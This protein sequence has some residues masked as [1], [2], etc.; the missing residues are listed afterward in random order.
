MLNL[1]LQ[2][3]EITSGGKDQLKVII[4]AI[5]EQETA[6]SKPKHQIDLVMHFNPDLV[7]DFLSFRRQ[8][9]P[10]IDSAVSWQ[11]GF[12]LPPCVYFP[13]TVQLQETRII[14][15]SKS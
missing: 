10:N 4:K 6:I 3:N 2:P 15:P 7:S 13:C 8:T 12:A 9:S 14:L 5:P 1:P 11:V